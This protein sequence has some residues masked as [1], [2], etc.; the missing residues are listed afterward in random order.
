MKRLYIIFGLFT[1]PLFLFTI[2]SLINISFFQGL[3]SDFSN[4][5]I[6]ATIANHTAPVPY[7][8]L[9]VQPSEW[10]LANVSVPEGDYSL[11]FLA[12]QQNAP[13]PQQQQNAAQQNAP[14]E[15]QQNVSQQNSSPFLSVLFFLF[16][17]SSQIAL[18]VL[19]FNL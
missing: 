2:P 11:S 12:S 18:S 8:L 3:E 6:E 10:A 14:P 13:P 4:L 15:P 17:F 16:A 7:E 9:Q 5:L 19:G 1:I